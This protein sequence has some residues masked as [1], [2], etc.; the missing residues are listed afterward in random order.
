M[1]KNRTPR[2][3]EIAKYEGVGL[4]SDVV[5]VGWGVGRV[6][7]AHTPIHNSALQEGPT[8]SL[9]SPSWTLVRLCFDLLLVPTW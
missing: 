6:G 2:C 9:V 8:N 1:A 5:V 3:S 4:R 7:V